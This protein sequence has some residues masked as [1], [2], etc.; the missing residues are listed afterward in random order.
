MCGDDFDVFNGVWNSWLLAFLGGIRRC[1]KRVI[2]LS[3]ERACHLWE[4]VNIWD[5]WI[6]NSPHEESPPSPYIFILLLNLCVSLWMGC[7]VLCWVVLLWLW[8]ICECEGVK[9]FVSYFPKVGGWPRWGL[10]WEVSLHGSPFLSVFC[11]LTFYD[12]GNLELM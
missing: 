10:G 1:M 8:I 6:L 2:L 4:Y 9:P 12:L 11:R 3:L 7:I 5:S